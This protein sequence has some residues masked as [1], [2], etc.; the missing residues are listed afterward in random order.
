MKILAEE[1][2]IPESDLRDKSAFAEMGVDSLLALTISGKFREELGI[3]ISSSMFLDYP[4][5]LD[6]KRFLG[7]N[8]SGSDRQ[9]S[10]PSSASSKEGS[11]RPSTPNSEIE[12]ASSATDVEDAPPLECGDSKMVTLIRATIAEETGVAVEEIDGSTD[13]AGLGMDSLMSLTITGKLRESTGEDLPSDFFANNGTMNGIEETLGVQRKPKQAQE[14]ENTT[15]R[16]VKAEPSDDSAEADSQ[17]DNSLVHT[18]ETHPN[19]TSVLLQGSSNNPRALF[20]FPDGSGSATSYSSLPRLA[21]QSPLAVYALNSPFL[22]SP[23]SFPPSIPLLASLYLN[24]VRRR[25]AHGPYI[26]GGWSAGGVIAYEA[27]LQLHTE[28]EV[29]ERLVLIDAPCPLELGLLP[30]H[31]HEWFNEQGILGQDGNSN[32]TPDW[33]IPHFD[34]SVRALAAYQPGLAIES[35]PEDR[36]PKTYM[37]WAKDGVCKYPT[38]PRPAKPKGGAPMCMRWLLEN[39]EGERLKYGGWDKVLGDEAIVETGVVEGVNHFTLMTDGVERLGE[40]IDAA[41]M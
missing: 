29:V 21:A 26:L 7:E 39:R 37:I 40:L 14:A 24:E 8:E 6:L 15:K 36:I 17:P 2:G 1:I 31:L 10:T 41:I 34:A 32:G 20:L 27:C 12:S 28:G 33:L 19:A 18:P 13:L 16:E 11:P 30:S 5:V 3:D 4:T 23:T 25:R 9:A 35:Q 38:D 22:K